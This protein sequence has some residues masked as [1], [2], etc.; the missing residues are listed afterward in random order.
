M[1]DMDSPSTR[2]LLIEGVP[3]IGKTTLINSAVRKYVESSQRIRSL[4]HLTQAHTYF[5]LSPDEFDSSVAAEQ[6]IAH[7]EQIIGVLTWLVSSV[8]Y[9]RRKI[10]LCTIDTLHITHCFRPGVIGWDAVA[11]FDRRLADLGCRLIFLRASAQTIWER[12]IWDRRDN[13]FITY[14]GRKYGD[15][16]EGIHAYYV[17]EQRNM[18]EIAERSGMRGVILDCDG[19]ASD[20]SGEVYDYWMGSGSTAELNRG[21]AKATSLHL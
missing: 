14:Y 15:S 6:N 4:L 19:P 17:Q 7:L 3:G 16:I 10:F 2:I 5:P 11:S 13:E 18:L 8:S 1:G 20:L 21:V 9:E 12:T